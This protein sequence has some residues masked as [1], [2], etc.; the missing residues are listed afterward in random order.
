MPLPLRRALAH[1]SDRTHSDD[2]GGL[3]ARLY[4]AYIERPPLGRAVIRI[5]WGGDARPM[6][7]SLERLRRLSAGLTVVDAACGAGLALHYLEPTRVGRYV[8]IDSSPTMLKRAGERGRR[9]G[10]RHLELR[11]GDVTAMPLEDATA[12]V[13]LLYNALHVVS[14][15]EQAVAEAMRCLKP[16]GRLEGTMLLRGERRRVDRLFEREQSK[17]SGL[18]GLG[19]TLADLR[20]WLE[21]F[22]DVQ[23]ERGGA[24]VT[25]RA[26]RA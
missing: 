9:R 12:D 15:P 20:R 17:P 1:L 6:Y 24:L 10:F 7:A 5:I 19:G 13:Y 14:D 3:A 18:L 4:S 8:G 11:I 2:Y 22:S 16:G 21:A 25:F 23:V 26:R